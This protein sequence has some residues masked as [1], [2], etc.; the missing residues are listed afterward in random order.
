MDETKRLR[1][2]HNFL[3]RFLLGDGYEL[4][5]ENSLKYGHW[6]W[7]AINLLE[8]V[9]KDDMIAHYVENQKR[10]RQQAQNIF[11]GRHALLTVLSSNTEVNLDQLRGLCNEKNISG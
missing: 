1:K 4:K 7:T 3:L 10:T 6:L 5:E 11:H 2:R 8:P 9:H